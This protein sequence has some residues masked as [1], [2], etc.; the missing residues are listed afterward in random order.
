MEEGKGSENKVGKRSQKQESQQ[1]ISHHF[2]STSSTRPSGKGAERAGR[3]V[4][5]IQLSPRSSSCPHRA[6]GQPPCA[7]SPGTSAG[8]PWSFPPS[9]HHLCFPAL[10]C[11]LFSFP[12]YR[13]AL[14]SGGSPKEICL[15]G[16]AQ[17]LLTNLRNFFLPEEGGP[18]PC[19]I[20]L[21]LLCEYN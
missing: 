21:Q 20:L 16:P 12:F 7:C 13:T 14:G 1:W 6:P 3:Y 4:L 10:P 19:L 9:L 15:S 17:L 8:P 5:D 18:Q 2:H 11:S